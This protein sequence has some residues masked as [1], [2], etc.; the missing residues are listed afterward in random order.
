MERDYYKSYGRLLPLCGSVNLQ[1][2]VAVAQR[3][4]SWEEELA[5]E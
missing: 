3:G 2:Q 5:V 1:P 4:G